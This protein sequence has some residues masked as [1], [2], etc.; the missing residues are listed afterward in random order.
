LNV[1][2]ATNGAEAVEMFKDKKYDL[3]LMDANMPVL[4]GIEATSQIIE[5]EKEKKLEHTPI[6]ALTANALKGDRDRF[7]AAGM[8]E[9]L[10][11]PIDNGKLLE[12]LQ[13]FL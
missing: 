3:I 10:S 7:L 5:I 9:Y 11:K 2:I 13:L 1:T 8:D 12:A 4:N 6:I